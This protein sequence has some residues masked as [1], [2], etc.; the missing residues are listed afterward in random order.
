M[1]ALEH[2]SNILNLQTLGEAQS[3]R[4][5]ALAFTQVYHN[6]EPFWSPNPHLKLNFEPPKV[7][8]KYTQKSLGNV[9]K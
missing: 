5:K 7:K 6:K 1:K 2:V 9:E 4:V 3:L 8:K